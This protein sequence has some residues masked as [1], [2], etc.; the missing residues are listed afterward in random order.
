MT[1]LRV[2]TGHGAHHQRLGDG[3]ARHLRQHV[4]DQLHHHAIADLAE[5]VDRGGHRLLHR[6]RLFQRCGL[7]A[8]KGLELVLRHQ[9]PPFT[10][11][12][13]TREAGHV[14]AARRRR[15]VS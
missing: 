1:L 5:V 9:R 10:F 3:D 15:A 8:D 11:C 6:P 2:Q 14:P 12:G 13:A 4:V 7:A